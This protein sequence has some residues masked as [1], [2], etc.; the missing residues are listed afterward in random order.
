[1]IMTVLA[2]GVAAFRFGVAAFGADP[3]NICSLMRH[4][5]SIDMDFPYSFVCPTR[6]KIC[7]IG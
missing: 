7:L 3:N 4:R 2:M 1:M 5:D 6:T